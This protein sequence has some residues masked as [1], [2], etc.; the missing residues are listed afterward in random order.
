[1]GNSD[2]TCTAN[3]ERLAAVQRDLEN[4]HGG[5]YGEYEGSGR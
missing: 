4:E 1:M 2:E 5:A 3:L